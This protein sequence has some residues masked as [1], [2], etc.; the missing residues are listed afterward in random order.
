MENEEQREQDKNEMI[1]DHMKRMD[2]FNEA[3]SKKGHNVLKN[4]AK[5]K[6]ISKN[7]SR[8]QK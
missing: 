2:Q 6:A 8:R 7:R 1:T 4:L 3:F 5:L